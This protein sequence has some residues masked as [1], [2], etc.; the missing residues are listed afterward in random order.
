MDM[1]SG[2][3][4]GKM[5]MEVTYLSSFIPESADTKIV[6]MW[7]FVLEMEMGM[8]MMGMEMGMG[9]EIGMGMGMGMEISYLAHRLRLETY[10]HIHM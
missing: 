2:D 1:A 10:L 3:G 6:M 4:D 5:A 7:R 9:M 8:V